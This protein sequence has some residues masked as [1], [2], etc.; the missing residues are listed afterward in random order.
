MIFRWRV[1]FE[2]TCDEEIDVIDHADSYVM[3]KVR[4]AQ[5]PEVCKGEFCG[6]YTRMLL[7]N[8]LKEVVPQYLTVVDVI[9]SEEAP[10]NFK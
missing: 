4:N 6:A 1:P 10:H 8:I 7:G 2:I 5:G 9:P 3:V